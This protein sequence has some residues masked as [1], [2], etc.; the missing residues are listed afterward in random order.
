[1]DRYRLPA[2]YGF[3]GEILLRQHMQAMQAQA[4]RQDE[5]ERFLSFWG[6]KIRRALV[7]LVGGSAALLYFNGGFAWTTAMTVGVC[8]TVVV[9]LLW[10]LWAGRIPR[11]YQLGQILLVWSIA[12]GFH[13]AVLIW[14]WVA[15]GAATA[16]PW[17]FIEFGIV[18]LV[19]GLVQVRK[20][21][22][23]WY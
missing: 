18:G 20:N 5:I 15:Y 21:D 1:M 13:L 22:L 17:L 10:I 11:E 4:E 14:G 16:I 23:F 9:S 2:S 12:S 6:W 3:I 19:S 8:A 7:Y